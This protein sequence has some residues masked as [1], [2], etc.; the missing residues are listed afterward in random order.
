MNLQHITRNF[1]PTVRYDKMEGKQYLVVPSIAIVEG[2]H[3]GSNGPLLY[4]KE[5]IEKTPQV[6][7]TKPVTVYHPEINGRGLS[8]CDPAILDSRKVGEMMNT[9]AEDGKLKTELWIDE[10]AANKVD[11]RILDAVKNGK[12]MELSTGLFTD[13]DLVEG[14][15]NGEP[16]S[17]VARNY[18]PDHLAILP[19]KIGA[20]SIEDGA[21]FLRVNAETKD[22]DNDITIGEKCADDFFPFLEAA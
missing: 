9:V 7:N 11:K 22:K 19:D 15:W 14:E 5:E 1:R 3:N 21:G 12:M 16:Y 6:W 10:A 8:A 2:V 18:R 4:P 13:N 17:A 20:C